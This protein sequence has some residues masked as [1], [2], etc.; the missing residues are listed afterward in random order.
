MSVI[1]V[2]FQMFLNIL[3]N[4]KIWW[5]SRLAFIG[6]EFEDIRRATIFQYTFT[7]VEIKT[8]ASSVYKSQY[9]WC[10]SVN[11]NI[12][13]VYMNHSISRWYLLIKQI[14]SFDANRFCEP[15]YCRVIS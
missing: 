12:S 1:N 2:I 13:S 4:S 8:V 6:I 5:H 3:Y 9:Y 7:V 11:H 10:L 14:V 15:R